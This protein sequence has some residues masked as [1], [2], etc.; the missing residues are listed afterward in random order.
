MRKL[1]FVLCSV[2]FATLTIAQT[3]PL[4]NSVEATYRAGL[5]HFF[6]KIQKGQ[7]V[8]VAYLGG[9]ITRAD[10]GWRTKTFQWLQSNYPQAQFVEIMA[11]IGGTGSDFGAY[12]LQNHVLQHT[13][14]LVFVEFAVNDNGKS[15]QDV[16]ESMEGIVRQ[17][18]QQNR[19]TDICFVYTFSRPQ[20]DFYQ[21]GTFPVSASA[22]EVIADYYQIPSISMAF[23]AVN[24]ITEGK[25]V[26]QG[27][28]GSTT[29]PMVF[30]ADGV[31][32]FPETGHKVY[33]ETVKKHLIH[34]QLVGK[35]GKHALKKALM[36][37]NL[38]KASLLAL[39]KIE[40]SSGWPRVDSVVVGKAYASLLTSVIASDDTS[41]YI[42]VRFKGTS[43]GIVDVIGPSSG[44]IR[45]YIDNEPPRYINRFDE[46]ATYYRM[47]YTIING[48]KEGNHEVTIKVSP[49]KLDKALI[50]Q[51]RNNKINNPKLYEK[52]F[53]Y[54]GGILVK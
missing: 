5:P 46:Y 54:L 1:L 31:H 52:Q 25:M 6:D 49:E 2:F 37:N 44:Q 18:W 14:D 48:L 13:P 12:R 39:D 30:S 40:K 27:Q 32:P 28:A 10:H 34:L 24:L 11:A 4:V 23:P 42:K 47:N 43:F 9:S 8:K 7:S 3:E 29:D 50:L 45:V 38:E 53:L 19:S 20:L 17:I 21:R 41:E 15:A 51:K 26:L 33:A 35:K 36:P 22:M 16:K